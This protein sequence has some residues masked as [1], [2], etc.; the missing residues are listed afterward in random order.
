MTV[1]RDHDLLFFRGA[2]ATWEDGRPQAE[3]SWYVP[4][5]PMETKEIEQ[6]IPSS[7]HVLVPPC[8]SLG[9]HLSKGSPFSRHAILPFVSAV[10][11]PSSGLG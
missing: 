8:H 9:K 11:R 10:F 6:Y 1:H 7:Q 5:V 4:E 3:D 2:K